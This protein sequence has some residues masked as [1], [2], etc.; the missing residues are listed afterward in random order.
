MYILSDLTSET[1]YTISGFTI[2]GTATS[3]ISGKLFQG[4]ATHLK[5]VG[6]SGILTVTGGFSGSVTVSSPSDSFKVTSDSIVQTS[7]VLDNCCVYEWNAATSDFQEIESRCDQ[8]FTCASTSEVNED[9]SAG[10]E[11]QKI[12]RECR[13]I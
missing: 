2:S 4:E 3:D 12:E 5:L 1:D 6:S 11:N 13:G 8:G 7:D 10:Y 9:H